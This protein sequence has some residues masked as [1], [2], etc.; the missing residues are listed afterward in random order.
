[1]KRL[2]TTDQNYATKFQ[3]A[4]TNEEVLP[5]LQKLMENLDEDIDKEMNDVQRELFQNAWRLFNK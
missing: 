1:M 5:K 4:M 2:G 3:E